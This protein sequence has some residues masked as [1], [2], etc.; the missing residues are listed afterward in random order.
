MSTGKPE[1]KP[2]F[3]FLFV[4][5]KHSKMLLL[6]VLCLLLKVLRPS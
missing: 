2:V 5:E 6:M 3:C 4:Q 1:S